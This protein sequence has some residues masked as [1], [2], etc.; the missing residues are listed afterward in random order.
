[1]PLIVRQNVRD[2]AAALLRFF[3]SGP[4]ATAGQPPEPDLAR[5]G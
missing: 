4:E 2:T 1:M 3:D 5:Q